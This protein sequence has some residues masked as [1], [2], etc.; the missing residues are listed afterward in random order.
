M[1][2]GGKNTQSSSA[3]VSAIAWCMERVARGASARLNSTAIRRPRVSISK[4][5]SEPLCTA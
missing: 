1:L 2:E 4:S 5:N 3:P